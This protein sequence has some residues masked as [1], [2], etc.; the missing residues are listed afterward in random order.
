MT[1]DTVLLFQTNSM[2]HVTSVEISFIQQKES[3]KI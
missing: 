3:E 1:P 2:E